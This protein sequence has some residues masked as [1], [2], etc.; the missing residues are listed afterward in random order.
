VFPNRGC[1]A[2]GDLETAQ[3]DPLAFTQSICSLNGPPCLSPIRKPTERIRAAFSA[4][5]PRT[6]RPR[7]VGTKSA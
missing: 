3:F 7:K 4:G 6:A 5:A 2:A 1:L